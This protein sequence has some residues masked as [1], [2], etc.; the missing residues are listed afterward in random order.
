MQLPLQTMS[1]MHN[2]DV[3]DLATANGLLILAN[4][5]R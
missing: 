2:H 3:R 1:G 4:H 5:V